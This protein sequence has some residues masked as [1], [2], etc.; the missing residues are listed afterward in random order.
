M[1]ELRAKILGELSQIKQGA[2]DRTRIR[3][4][5]SE[6]LIKVTITKQLFPILL[7]CSD[8]LHERSKD[9]GYNANSSV[10]E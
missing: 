8:T 2:N 1:K 9:F 6:L 4:N 5:I 7:E 3:N 10:K